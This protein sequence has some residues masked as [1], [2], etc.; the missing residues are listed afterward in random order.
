ME[1]KRV[2]EMKE[3]QVPR[4]SRR[5]RIRHAKKSTILGLVILL[6]VTIFAVANWPRPHAAKPK[7]TS[8]ET[9]APQYQ[10]VLPSG[11]TIK[12]LG[13]WQ[14]L[15]PPNG[16]SFYAFTD[17]LDKVAINVTQQQLPKSFQSNTNQKV[18]DL[19]KSYNATSKLN[20]SGLTVYIGIS[21][22]GPQSVIF[23]KDNL[24]VFIKSER[25]IANDSWERYITSLG[26]ASSTDKTTY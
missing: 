24:L 25:K 3:Q 8:Q 11:K 13:G 7:A 22:R 20:V 12:D 19:A 18:A 6:I 10:T 21:A 17:S 23:T 5:S 15:T 1:T 14:K 2:E 16:S 9:A 26:I 4:T